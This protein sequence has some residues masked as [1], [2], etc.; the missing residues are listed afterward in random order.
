MPRR[1]TQKSTVTTL[2]P[3]VRAAM[4]REAL[5]LEENALCRTLEAAD[6]LLRCACASLLR[7]G[8][9][10]LPRSRREPRRAKLALQEALREARARQAALRASTARA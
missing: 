5:E 6:D 4:E 10:H 1:A 7:R 3:P 9:A 2:H 8:V